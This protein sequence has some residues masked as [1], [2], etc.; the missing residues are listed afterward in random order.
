MGHT[1][2]LDVTTSNSGTLT[3]QSQGVRCRRRDPQWAARLSGVVHR[4]W[5]AKL[6]GIEAPPGLLAITDGVIE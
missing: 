3:G 5:T 2:S 4:A 1:W 6:L